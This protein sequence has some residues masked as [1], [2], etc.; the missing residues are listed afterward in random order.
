MILPFLFKTPSLSFAKVH[1]HQDR[2]GDCYTTPQ[3]GLL[4]WAR[5]PHRYKEGLAVLQ[6]NGRLRTHGTLSEA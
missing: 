2:T 4:Q 1:S 5:E 3:L 6:I